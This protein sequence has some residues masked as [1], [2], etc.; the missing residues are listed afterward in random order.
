MKIYYTTDEI[1]KG[2]DDLPPITKTTL[3]NLRSARKLKY[4]KIGNQCVYK[5][6]WVQAYI[7]NNIVEV[8]N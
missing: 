4:S 5:K 6:E 1:A 3:R 7:D 2:L 8:A